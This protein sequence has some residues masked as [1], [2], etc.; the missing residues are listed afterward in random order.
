[1][2]LAIENQL[3]NEQASEIVYYIKRTKTKMKQII[4][5]LLLLALFGSIVIWVVS[6]AWAP[7]QVN[8]PVSWHDSHFQAEQLNTAK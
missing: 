6:C 4:K 8:V 5:N 2:T 3:I 7:L 1:M